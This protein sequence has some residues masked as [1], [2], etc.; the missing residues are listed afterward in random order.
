[1]N[2]SKLPTS[3][4]SHDHDHHHH[5]DHS[6]REPLLQ[7]FTQRVE[8]QQQ[9]LLHQ[10]HEVN[11]VK[12]TTKSTSNPNPIPL[13]PCLLQPKK[14][15]QQN[16]SHAVEKELQ[17]LKLR[18]AKLET[19]CPSSSAKQ[20]EAMEKIKKKN[21]A[22][23]KKVSELTAIVDE[24]KRTIA[25]VAASVDLQTPVPSTETPAAGSTHDQIIELQTPVPQSDDEINDG[26]VIDDLTGC[27]MVLIFLVAVFIGVLL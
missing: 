22:L 25:A 14:E 11:R 4:Y 5:H 24:M 27:L 26:V 1:M 19:S 6:L 16:I 21:A 7:N 17:E 12:E 13:I 20:G 23:E 2:Y 15:Q 3:H 18:V 8:E 10:I 9:E